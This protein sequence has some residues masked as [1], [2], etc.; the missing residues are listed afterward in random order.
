MKRRVFILWLSSVFITFVVATIFVGYALLRLLPSYQN[1]I[2]EMLSS[3]TGSEVSLQIEYAD[4]H[5]INP[6][7]EISQIKVKDQHFSLFIPKMTVRINALASLK[8]WHFVTQSVLIDKPIIKLYP[9]SQKIDYQFLQSMSVEEIDQIGGR[10]SIILDYLLQQEQLT[11]NQMLIVV[12]TDNNQLRWQLSL[13]A[14]Y[15]E[16][17]LNKGLLQLTIESQKTAKTGQVNFIAVIEK[18]GEKYYFNS[19]LHDKDQ[20]LVKAIDSLTDEVRLKSLVDDQVHF[21]IESSTDKLE[22]ISINGKISQADFN[23]KLLSESSFDGIVFNLR[24]FRYQHKFVLSANPLSFITQDKKY[25]FRSALI[26]LDQHRLMV[27][28]P[29]LNLADFSNLVQ[30]SSVD[31][32]KNINL[33]GVLNDVR[34]AFDLQ[35]PSLSGIQLD[36]NFNNLG[37]AQSDHDFDFKGLSGKLLWQKNK[38][39]ILIDSPDFFM[40]KNRI[41]S[42]QWPKLSAKGKIELVNDSSQL[43]LLFTDFS[44]I[45][46]NIKFITNGLLTIPF[47]EPKDFTLDMVGDLKGQNLSTEYQSFL[48]TKGIPKPLYEWLM[49]CLYSANSFDAKVKIKGVAHEIPYPHKNGIFKIDADIKGA[50]LSPYFGLGDAHEVNA[51]L[52]FN[53]EYFSAKV[54]QG[55]LGNIPIHDVSVNIENIAP[56]VP[57]SLNISANGKTD[58]H[59]LYEYLYQTQYKNLI[60]DINHI[61]TYQGQLQ[62]QLGINIPLGDAEQKDHVFGRVTL[63]DG[64]IQAQQSMAQNL[65]AVNGDVQFNNSKLVIKK[66][67]SML[68]EYIPLDIQGNIDVGDLTNPQLA[69]QGS[70]SFPFGGVLAKI[71]PSIDMTKKTLLQGI[72]PVNFSIKGSMKHG[73]LNFDSN[74]LGLTSHLGA[75]FNKTGLEL[76]PLS[77][78]A[79]WQQLNKLVAPSQK[80]QNPQ[81]AR[82]L[83]WQVDSKLDINHHSKISAGFNIDLAAKLSSLE[84]YGNLGL[85][86]SQMLLNLMSI[87]D[88][89]GLLSPLDEGWQQLVQLNMPLI[90]KKTSTAGCLVVANYYDCVYRNLNRMLKP[91]ANI[92]IKELNVFGAQYHNVKLTAQTS[93]TYTHFIAQADGSRSVVISVPSALN[94]PIEVNADNLF[95]IQNPQSKDT[96]ANGSSSDLSMLLRAKVLRKV[97]NMNV[98]LTHLQ[99]GGYSI[100]NFLMAT[101]L[102]AGV[103]SIPVLS[104]Y[105]SVSKLLAT[106]F[107]SPT[108][109][110]LHVN[111]FSLNWGKLLD[112]F[113]HEEIVQ[114]ASG[115]LQMQLNWLGLLPSMK[116]VSGKAT[117]DLLNGVILSVDTGIAKYIGLLS[118]DSYFKRLF[119]SYNDF[120]HHGMPFNS[121]VGTYDIK[122]GIA[123][124]TPSVIIDTPSFALVIAGEVDLINK[125][126]NQRIKYQPHFSGTTAAVVGAFGGPVVAFATYLGGKLLGNTIFKNIGLVTFNVTGNWDDPLLKQVQ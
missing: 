21:S 65:Y 7:I 19:T 48:P 117:V 123:T 12:S 53:N 1:S 103:L 59:A 100:P 29:R 58:S 55:R 9:R 70:F 110:S 24:L 90:N 8:N 98:K 124:S 11:L 69:L 67:S 46:D 79:S 114:G 73:M 78:K 64:I 6:V 15:Q 23:T 116:K 49:K 34:F 60:E 45:N 43:R 38:A 16:S 5:G 17:A 105:D 82:E 109:S 44:L 102:R 104:A 77:F 63:K 22:S 89:Q 92:L 27:N 74:L 18:V 20:L 80:G 39:T 40:A 4:W 112:N 57:S 81:Q 61:A 111:I 72:L 107:L 13:S 41:F 83:N 35:N 25:T 36:A 52:H 66:L 87:I 31:W 108:K 37:I 10:W 113:G 126:L 125:Q 122:D 62:M 26:S 33:T 14:K 56:N 51:S 115:N 94:E 30:L 101:K 85:L 3:I 2:E 42:K 119:M 96:T 97:P 68:G 71:L 54:S 120:Q 106:G 93:N 99:L 86:S 75:P 95:F 32:R 121:V 118:L 28:I 84:I 91:K 50:S 47:A 88:S 76:L